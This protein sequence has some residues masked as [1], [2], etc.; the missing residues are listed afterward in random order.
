MHDEVRAA[1]DEAARRQGFKDANELAISRLLSDI[2]LVRP[3]LA[4][5]PEL[6]KVS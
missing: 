3:D 5:R 6:A 2:V 4:N 1:L